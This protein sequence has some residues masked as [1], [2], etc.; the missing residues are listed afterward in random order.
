[1]KPISTLEESERPREKLHA[2]GAG[3]LTDEE[4]LAILL[5]SGSKKTPLH[6]LSKRVLE[7]MNERN[8]GLSFEHLHQV[9]GIGPAKATTLLAAMELARRRIRPEGVKITSP[10]DVLPL[11]SHLA[12]KKQEHLVAVSLNGAHEVIATRIVTVGLVN[13]SQVHPRE[14]FAEP[15]TDRACAVII[16]HNHPSGEL[17][18]SNEDIEVTKRLE[19]AGDLLGIRLLDH[20]IFGRRGIRS[21]R[22]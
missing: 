21:V 8:G 3:A 5:G 4:L 19:S 18:P 16:A 22:G 12:D 6:T 13:C 20:L 9:D 1:M 14:V 7:V 10:S 11:V 17:T 15:I 2:R